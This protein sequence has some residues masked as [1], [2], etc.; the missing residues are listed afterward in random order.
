[1]TRLVSDR[2]DCPLWITAGFSLLEVVVATALAGALLLGLTLLLVGAVRDSTGLLENLSV[3]DLPERLQAQLGEYDYAELASGLQEG[4]VL[5]FAV[6]AHDL[7]IIRLAPDSPGPVP[8]APWIL[9]RLSATF[10]APGERLPDSLWL[11]AAV[12]RPL[13]DGSSRATQE[14]PGTPVVRRFAMLI[15]P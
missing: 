13:S 4:G 8:F 9:V 1:M 10:E 6:E 12:S 7:G 3:Q 5:M 2:A 15:R 14:A 11:T